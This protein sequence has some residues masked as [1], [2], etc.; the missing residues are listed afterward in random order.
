MEVKPQ[1]YN[2]PLSQESARPDADPDAAEAA[3][4]KR[5]VAKRSR[6][7]IQGRSLQSPGR[8]K[9][10][11]VELTSGEGN[12]IHLGTLARHGNNY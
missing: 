10:A 3:R 2:M 11:D 12:A 7:D 8:Q 5:V 9:Q 4:V 1:R 6:A